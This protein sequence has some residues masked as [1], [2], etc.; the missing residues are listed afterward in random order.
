MACDEEAAIVKAKRDVSIF[1]AL[2]FA[3]S[4]TAC[5][6][7]FD[8][9]SYVRNGQVYFDLNSGQKLPMFFGQNANCIKEIKV[10]VTDRKPVEQLFPDDVKTIHY[11][12]IVVW[13][14]GDFRLK[15]CIAS[16]PVRYGDAKDKKQESVAA[17]PLQNGVT[18]TLSIVSSGSGFGGHDFTIKTAVGAIDRSQ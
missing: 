4:L 15:E 17:K 18:Y 7:S 8:T 2:G 1:I 10:E 9:F 5:S 16:F 14:Y 3:L 13:K 12:E 11:P 6:Y